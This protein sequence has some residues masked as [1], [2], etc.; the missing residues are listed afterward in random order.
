MASE[1][2]DKK[3]E[4]VLSLYTRLLQGE[5][6]NKAIEAEHYGVTERSIQRDLQDIERFCDRHKKQND[7][8]ALFY[9]RHTHSVHLERTSKTLSPKEILALCKI[10]LDSKAFKKEKMT[11][12]LQRLIEN[13]LSD[14]SK[15][16]VWHL[17]KNELF[18]YIEPKH[19]KDFLD[20]L[21]EA[22][23]AIR[24]S[25]YITIVYERKHHN[26][27]VTRILQPLSI[28]FSE[29]YFYL[30]AFIK[31]DMANISSQNRKKMLPVVY[32]ID[33]ISSIQV[34]E[35]RFVIPYCN[36]FE[37]GQFR[38]RIPFMFG[39]ELMQVIFTYSGYDI[40][41]V[42]DRLPTATIVSYREETGIYTLSAEV[43]G[44]G[45]DMW[46]R[47]QGPFVKVLSKQVL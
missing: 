18:Y 27:V 34:S 32:R 20:I 3:T 31:E 1:E 39:G 10:L 4:R 38:R 26:K 23:K 47:S 2:Q 42:L 45:I 12:M 19:Q 17:I 29:Y 33:R 7:K 46:L 8:M 44:H 36:H 43:Y 6:I 16:E 35:K 30:I 24:F 21:W 40:D 22:G 15:N 25:H 5:E 13:C 14:D 11:N 37:E 28:L 9:N 41:A